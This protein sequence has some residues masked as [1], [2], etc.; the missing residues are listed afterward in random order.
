MQKLV[1]PGSFDPV[2]NGHI[3][4]FERAAAL[5]DEVVVAV[6]VNSSKKGLFAIEERV[7]ML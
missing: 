2:T 7:A 4:V 3:D 1:C 5:A 6:L